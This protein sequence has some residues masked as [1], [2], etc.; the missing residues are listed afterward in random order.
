MLLAVHMSDN[1]L[2]EDKNDELMLEV[3]DLF[4]LSQDMLKPKN[5]SFYQLN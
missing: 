2:R 1:G 3:L 5:D 4:G